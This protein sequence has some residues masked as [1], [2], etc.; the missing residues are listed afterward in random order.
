MNEPKKQIKNPR[1]EELR[2]RI[3]KKTKFKVWLMFVLLDL[4]Y[5]L[6]RLCCFFGFHFIDY[7]FGEAKCDRFNDKYYTDCKVCKKQ[8]R[9]YGYV[10]YRLNTNKKDQ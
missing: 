5:Y 8:F 6:Q 10:I 9:I 2:L 1:M 4:K 7:D 3:S